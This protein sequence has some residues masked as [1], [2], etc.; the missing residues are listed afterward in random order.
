M[1]KL[2][3]VSAIVLVC[4]AVVAGAGAVAGAQTAGND[5]TATADIEVT[6]AAVD[7]STVQ[8]GEAVGVSAT[9]EN[10]G[11]ASGS[12]TAELRIDGET[13]ETQRSEVDGGGSTAVGFSYTFQ[14]AGEYDVAVSGTQAGTVTVRDPA[15]FDV[16]SVSVSESTVETGEQVGIDVTV[17]N[18]GDTAGETDVRLA[19]NRD[20]I[21]SRTVS[22]ASG[23]TETV[24]FEQTFE[25]AGTYTLTA[26]GQAETTLT[27]T[28]PA[29]FTV[30]SAS[31]GTSSAT[32]G[33]PVEVSATVGNTGTEADEFTAEL[34]VDG[35]VRETRS[36]ALDGG[37]TTTVTF[38]PTFDAAGD[39]TVAVGNAS[40]GT[41]T[42][43]SPTES[44]GDNDEPNSGSSD[45]ADDEDD[46]DEGADDATETRT[47]QE[48]TPPPVTGPPTV[49]RATSDGRVSLGIADVPAGTSVS[50]SL[51]LSVGTTESV[52]LSAVELTFDTDT[53]QFNATFA[54]PDDGPTVRDRTLGYVVADATVNGSS[55]SEVQYT[56]ETTAA[57]DEGGTVQVYQRADDG[58]TKVETTRTGT[59]VIA[60]TTGFAPVAVVAS[61]TAPQKATDPTEDASQQP[62]ETSQLTVTSATVPADFV[63]R[64]YDATVRA[65]VENPTDS[66]VTE[67]L[68]VTVDGERVTTRSVQVDPGEQR[69]VRI[70]FP[71]TAGSVRVDGVS[72]GQV[73]TLPANGTAE[74]T[75]GSGPGFGWVAVVVA[76]GLLLLSGARRQ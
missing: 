18:T 17:A 12:F 32:T 46:A 59:T 41:V 4:T 26:N 64:G 31:L 68:A 45:P 27:V 44:D 72:A 15:T 1:G 67:T 55:V 8:S 65:T 29:A 19:A 10:T 66:A 63:R 36:V 14:E 37:E 48:E 74:T 33:E 38:T 57:S 9:L 13:V 47:L 24:S 42:V 34:R 49:T 21:G 30:E 3:A 54:A 5:E 76:L 20:Q 73:S 35:E 51:N 6:D 23:E 60:T 16:E 70:E 25:E 75:S 43:T 71:A 7:Q 50:E 11:D 69:T 40:A 52:A 61:S 39:Y 28:E 58:W 56:F 2:G 22:V 62:G 53:R